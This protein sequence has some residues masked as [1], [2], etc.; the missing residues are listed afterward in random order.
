MFYLSK[1]WTVHRLAEE[2]V[3]RFDPKLNADQLQQCLSKLLRLHGGSCHDTSSA[4][5]RCDTTAEWAE[6]ESYYLLTN[7]GIHYTWF[8]RSSLP[9][10]LPVSK[11]QI[12]LYYIIYMQQGNYSPPLKIWG[13][14]TVHYIIHV[15]SYTCTSQ[16]SRLG[17][18]VSLAIICL[19]VWATVGWVALPF[20][21]FFKLVCYAHVFPCMSVHYPGTSEA[22][23]H[24]LQLP[25]YVRSITSL[26][27]WYM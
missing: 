16:F 9:E 4:A 19:F 20:F 21:S 6:F 11:L 5:T 3:E 2:S 8:S 10:I 7:L 24:T 27:C 13:Y 23:M 15:H 22:V 1:W 12:V 14:S 26:Q 17:I 25:P 18:Q